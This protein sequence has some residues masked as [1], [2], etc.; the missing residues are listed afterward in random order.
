MV[1]KLSFAMQLSDPDDY[2]GG[3][4]CFLMRRANHILF[5]VREDVLFYLILA[6]NIGF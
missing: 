6:H 2:E 3:N 5:R 1:R 4:V